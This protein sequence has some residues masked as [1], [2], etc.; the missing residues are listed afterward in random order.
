M[1]P[2]R[3]V[4]LAALHALIERCSPETTYRRFHGAMGTGARRG[5]E[6]I[7]TPT[8]RHRSWVA[9]GPGGAVHGTTTLAWSHTGAVEVT[10]VVEDEQRRRGIGR[11]LV[12]AT[13]AAAR[14]AGLVTVDAHIQGDNRA[15]IDFLT[16]VA[17]GSELRFADGMLVLSIPVGAVDTDRVLAGALATEAA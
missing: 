10:I 1:R 6:R 7:A 3:P 11:A 16:T 4:D 15:A 14:R 9:V 13:A 5:L 2:A 17:P 8:D 12:A